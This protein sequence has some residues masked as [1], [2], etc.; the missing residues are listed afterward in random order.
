MKENL[1]AIVRAVLTLVGSFLIGHNVF[2][3]PLDSSTSEI[4]IGAVL[5]LIG[6]IWGFVDKTTT[7]DTGL[8]ALRSVLLVLGGLGVSWGLISSNVFEAISGFTLSLIPILQSIFSKQ[9]VKQLA[10]GII[11]PQ[12]VTLPGG[13]VVPNGKTVPP[14]GKTIIPPKQ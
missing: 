8:S 14:T 7:I 11:V 1:L 5:S 6:I 13:A 10:T 4:I 9:K 3:K 12:K 2:G